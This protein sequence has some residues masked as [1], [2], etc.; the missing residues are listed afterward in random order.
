MTHGQLTLVNY[1]APLALARMVSALPTPAQARPA[2]LSLHA[3][4]AALA[5]APP[6]STTQDSVWMEVHHA[7]ASRLAALVPIVH[8]GQ[9][10]L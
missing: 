8:W 5:S 1:S 7:L 3:V 9:C 10:V 4:P 6:L 2:A